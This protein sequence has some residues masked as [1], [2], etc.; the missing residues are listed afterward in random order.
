[1][2]VRVPVMVQDP[3]ASQ[4]GGLALT[5]SQTLKRE[6]HLLDGPVSERVAVLDLDA[7]TGLCRKGVRFRP[8]RGKTPGS[9]RLRLPTPED[10]VGPGGNQFR[11]VNVFATVLRTMTMF[12]EPDTLGRRL[13]WAFDAPQLLLVPHA[14]E[15]PNA[16]Y[17][18]LSHSIQF[19][20][21]R[22]D[23]PPYPTIYTSLSHDIIAHETAHAILDGI[24][25]DLYSAVTPQ[26]LALHEAIADLTS[27]IMAF[28]SGTLRRWVMDQ[29]GGR[30]DNATAFSW[31]AE[32]FGRA[33]DPLGRADYLRSVFNNKTLDPDDRTLDEQGRP[34]LVRRYEPHLLCQVLTG[35][36][37]TVMVNIHEQ[38]KGQYGGDDPAARQRAAAKA[39]YQA[40]QRFKRMILRALDFLPPGEV[41]FGD[42]GRAII[43]SDQASYPSL[44]RERTWICDEFV[45]RRMVPDRQ[46]LEVETNLEHP[47]LRD[48]DLEALL[49]D[50]WAAYDFANRQRELLRI[51]EDVPFQVRPRLD[52]TK[53]YY[54]GGGRRAYTRELLFK[55]AWEQADPPGRPSRLITVGTTLVVD[56]RTK[57]LRACLTTDHSAEQQADRDL[58]VRHLA[59]EGLIRLDQHAVGP[60]GNLLGGAVTGQTVNGLMRLHGTA[61]LLHI[62][63]ES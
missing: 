2:D 47:A 15:L 58:L 28:R 51:P 40:A 17:E 54:Q 32:E 37:Y 61:R 27:L 62:V 38:L 55:V 1:M 21:F 24:A 35:A 20:Y 34:N 41:S 57:R 10:L 4:A 25:P 52:V 26:S 14:G 12:E 48:A 8:P 19:F 44:Y 60:D 11:A 36:L 39:L 49:H 6:S 42:Y 3:L 13:T 59:A 18:R 5:E 29:T 50:D 7:E 22:A 56:W 31:I 30:I 63:G 33:R 53:L 46:A 23:Q 45:R 16:Y 9:Y 43:A